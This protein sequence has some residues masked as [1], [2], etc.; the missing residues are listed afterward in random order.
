LVMCG[1]RGLPDDSIAHISATNDAGNTRFSHMLNVQYTGNNGWI[2]LLEFKTND[3]Q[4]DLKT[5]SPYLDQWDTSSESQL[6]MSIPMDGSFYTPPTYPVTDEI[7]CLS[8]GFTEELVSTGAIASINPS[9]I[10]LGEDTAGE[11]VCAAHFILSVPRGATIHSA[12]L[13]FQAD[14][15]HTESCSLSLDVEDTLWSD[16]LAAEDYNISSRT[17]T[18]SPVSWANVESWTV[19]NRYSTPDIKSLIQHLVDQAAWNIDNPCCIVISQ[20]AASGRRV[21][22]NASVA[23][24]APILTVQWSL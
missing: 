22:E 2:S 3:N 6:S 9:D 12:T 15:S 7:T 4:V 24:Q 8:G 20:A 1:H 17:L 5:Y 23:A 11:Q 10:E 19:G 18:G 14:E 13:S 16:D 21:A